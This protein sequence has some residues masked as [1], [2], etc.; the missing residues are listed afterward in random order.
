MRGGVQ[1]ASGDGRLYPIG[2]HCYA[3][4]VHLATAYEFFYGYRSPVSVA[5]V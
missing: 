4:A 1:P 5:V 3:P 2:D